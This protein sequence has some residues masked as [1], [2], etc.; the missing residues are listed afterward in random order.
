M[1]DKRLVGGC[2]RNSLLELVCQRTHHVPH[3]WQASNRQPVFIYSLKRG[4]IYVGRAEFD[5]MGREMVE[6][7][8]KEPVPHVANHELS[9]AGYLVN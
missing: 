3:N 4:E 8:R 9:G 7:E 5:R 6:Y 2:C 1:A